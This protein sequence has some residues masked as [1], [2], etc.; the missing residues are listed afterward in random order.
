MGDLLNPSKQTYVLPLLNKLYRELQDRLISA[1]VETFNKYGYILA[2][3]PAAT[4]N[5]SYMVS[6]SYAGYFDGQNNWLQWR[7]P[8]DML[9]PMELWERQ[10]GNNVWNPMKPVSDSIST[11]PIVPRFNNW[12][13]QTDV[14][15]LPPSSQTNDLKFKYLCY[16]PDITS[17]SSPIMVPRCQSALSYRLAAEVAKS[18][19]GLEMA[20]IWAKDA[21]TFEQAIVNRSG[22]KESYMAFFRKPFRPGR[23]RGRRS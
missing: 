16:A 7:L 18:R 2:L 17:V 20:A 22:R 12:D 4:N 15:Y 19:G 14:L 21:D 8:P 23:R 3:P 13:Y 9:K 6:I 11:R 10:T 1:S 5:P